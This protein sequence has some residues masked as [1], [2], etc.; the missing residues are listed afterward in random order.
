MTN[1]TAHLYTPAQWKAAREKTAA[2]AG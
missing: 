1:Q 2:A